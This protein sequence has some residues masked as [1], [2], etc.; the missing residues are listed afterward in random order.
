MAAMATTSMTMAE[1]KGAQFDASIMDRMAIS[2]SGGARRAANCKKKGRRKLIQRKKT[3]SAAYILAE[4]RKLSCY[5]QRRSPID[6]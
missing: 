5:D 3:G 4:I 1:R 2:D 6:P